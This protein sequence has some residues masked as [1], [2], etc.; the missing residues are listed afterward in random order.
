ME[1]LKFKADW[2]DYQ[3][4]V[5]GELEKHLG[6]D[7][8]H[9]VAA[10]GS[11]KTI[12]GLEVMRRL[13]K[14][15]IILAPTIT[16]RNQWVERLTSM[17]LP[18]GEEKPDWISKNI[19][20]PKPLLVLTYQALH[21]A[22]TGKK[23]IELEED[24]EGEEDPNEELEISNPS[25]LKSPDPIDGMAFLKK[26]KFQTLILDE[27]HHLRNEWWKALIHL[28]KN[29]NRPTVVSLTAT[30]PYDVDFEEWKKYENLCGTMDA[31]ISVPELV[32][33][34]DLCPHQDYV[35]FSV[36]KEKEKNKLNHFKSDISKFI[37]AL[38]SND[39]FLELLVTHPWWKDCQNHVEDILANPKFFSSMIIYL[40]AMGIQPS[41]Q[42]IKIL[43]VSAREIP[44]LNAEW[45]ETLLNGSL[46]GKLQGFPEDHPVLQNLQKE[47]KKMGAIERRKITLDNT[48]EIQK[49]LNSSLAKLDSIVEIC[50]I[51]AGSLGDRLR[52]VVLADYIRKGELPTHSNDKVSIK[53][54]GV[55][56]IFEYLRL[57]KIP[58]VQLGI[59]TGSLIFIPSTAKSLLEK[60][61]L[62]LKIEPSHLRFS[63]LIHDANFLSVEILG[64]HRQKI[65]QLITEVFNAGGIN[66]LIG[67]Q[68]LL[69]EG[70]DAPSINTLILASYVGSY[71]LSN[72]MRGRAIRID[73][74]DP[75]K[76]AN[77]WHLVTLDLFPLQKKFSEWMKSGV[78]PS[79]AVDPFDE[80]KQDLGSD[81][82]LLRRRFRA[83]E[84]LSYSH[85]VVIEN[86]FKRLGLTTV[87]WNAKSIEQLNQSMMVRAKDRHL[88]PDLWKK[89]LEGSSPK[90]EMRERIETNFVPRSF[91]LG[92]TLKF[93]I[94][95]AF[96]MGILWGSQV[97]AE[98]SSK[99]RPWIVLLVALGVAFLYALPKLLKALYL[100]IRNGS[101]ENSLGQLAKAVLDTLQY[102]NKI[103]TPSK[104]LRIETAKNKLGMALCRLDGATPRE[105]KL[106]LDSLQEVVG[107]TE[108]PRYLLVRRTSFAGISGKDYHP[109]PSIIGQHKENAVYFKKAWEKHVGSIRLV[110]TRNFKGRLVLLKARTRSLASAFQKK[111][112]RLCVWE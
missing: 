19:R 88:L 55:V 41:S 66:V 8:L 47:L 59:L 11:G 22:F 81:L 75:N 104:K 37:Q 73:P 34:G 18:S 5:L 97:L 76:V 21:A 6:D 106:F 90:P 49:L 25:K 85:P 93:L 82:S 84:G 69:G 10:P 30:P 79:H 112:D 62:K 2:R 78:W 65:V 46:L 28:K 20:E 42:A 71:M 53:R 1:N 16:I 24:P 40:N 102:M 54:I 60:L 17:F 33:R 50:K 39:A 67:T 80:I 57:A 51:E 61:A 96:L 72:Q 110:Y 13:A 38:K 94:M 107:P 48:K 105:R 26:E 108:N 103:Q 32:K 36:P 58:G 83:F 63:E 95:N 27:A 74:N 9:I 70:W 35:Y 56:P 92:N 31:E 52:M 98:N 68:A 12:L 101:L 29:L 4:R 45:L 109:V 100:L 43:G 3:A 87:R 44:A 14:P 7:H 111:S 99:G 89:A 23:D 77:I 64:S 91:V 15:T 86:G